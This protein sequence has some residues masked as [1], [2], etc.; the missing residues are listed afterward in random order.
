MPQA[1]FLPKIKLKYT[2][3]PFQQVTS[4]LVTFD[5][6]LESGFPCVVVQSC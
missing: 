2:N 5:L 4:T 1:L 3:P 6:D